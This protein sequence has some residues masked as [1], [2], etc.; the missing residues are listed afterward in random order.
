MYKF[1]LE[2]GVIDKKINVK[3]YVGYLILSFLIF[4]LFS[5]C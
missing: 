4:P 5:V 2:L 3:I 1:I